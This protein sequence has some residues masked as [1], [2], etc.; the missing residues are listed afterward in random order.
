MVMTRRSWSMPEGS[1]VEAKARFSE[2]LARARLGETQVITSRGKP[3]A[4][5]VP[6]DAEFVAPRPKLD[7]AAMRGHIERLAE[8]GAKAVDGDAFWKSWKDEQR[9]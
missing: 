1:V 7:V 6:A 9:Y 2:L 8:D 3:V 4:K 5:L